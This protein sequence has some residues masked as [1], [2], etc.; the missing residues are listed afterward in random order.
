M[1]IIRDELYPYLTARYTICAL[2]DCNHQAM[3]A[4]FEYRGSLDENN[5]RK[6]RD[7]RKNCK[8]LVSDHHSSFRKYFKMLYADSLYNRTLYHLVKKHEIDFI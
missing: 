6:M 8:L 7:G 1:I 3:T 2:V 4:L 5:A